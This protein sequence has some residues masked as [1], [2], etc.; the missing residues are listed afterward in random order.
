MSTLFDLPD[1]VDRP[2]QT[3]PSTPPWVTALEARTGALAS[4]ASGRAVARP[5]TRCRRWTLQGYDAPLIAGHA[6]VDPNPLTPQL[7]AAAVI[8][9]MPTWQL[10]GRPGAYQL[11]P[12]HE[13]GVHYIGTARPAGDVVVLAAHRCAYPPLAPDSIPATRSRTADVVGEPPF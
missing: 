6:V 3:T 9:A 8:L 2:A 5:C 12:R 4:L 1:D 10:W 13:P 7:E 11:T